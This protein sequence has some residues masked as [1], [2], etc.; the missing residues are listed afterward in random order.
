MQISNLGAMDQLHGM[1]VATS[2]DR[3]RGRSHHPR[4][5]DDYPVN[6]CHLIYCMTEFASEITDV[7]L[8]DYIPSNTLMS[9]MGSSRDSESP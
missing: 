1:V 4:N 2:L 6:T 8:P 3:L 5:Y 9:A 7:G